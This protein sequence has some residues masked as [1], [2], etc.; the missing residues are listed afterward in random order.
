MTRP[1]PA[2]IF[3]IARLSARNPRFAA[4]VAVRRAAELA[5]RAVPGFVTPHPVEIVVAVS[6]ACELRC[7]MCGI[8][9]IMKRPQ[10]RGKRITRAELFPALCEAASWRPRPYVKLTGG[11]PLLLGGELLGMLEDCRRLGLPSRLSTNGVRLADP[12]IARSLVKTGVN[13]VTVSLDGPREVH[14]AMRGRD[15]AFDRTHRGIRNLLEARAASGGKRPLIQVSSVI[16]PANQGRLFELFS[17]VRELSPD[18]WNVQLLNYVSPSARIEADA[19]ARSW[20]LSPGAWD[21]FE[22]D[23]ARLVNPSLVAREILRIRRGRP[24]FVVSFLNAG[25]FDVQTMRAYHAGSGT[26]LSRSRCRVP[27]FAMHIVPNGDMVFCIDYPYVT[28]GNIRSGRLKEAWR[29]ERAEGFR[30]MME[31]HRRSSSA[32][33]PQC[34]RCNWMFN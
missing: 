13:V 26:P 6:S 14:N 5:C 29:S 8:R 21:A 19:L 10:F 16:S 33:P 1:D 2:N 4:A 22:T 9:K 11:E 32:N 25:G 24:G 12:A 3:G 27:S 18:W 7:E 15:F 23:A 28:Y 17:V 31:R 30:R 34:L 20:G